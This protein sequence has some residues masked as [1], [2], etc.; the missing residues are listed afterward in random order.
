[1]EGRD[2]Q[3]LPPLV[4]VEDEEVE[5]PWL[6]AHP[7]V[8]EGAAQPAAEEQ[9]ATQPAVDQPPAEEAAA[10]PAIEHQP[11]EQPADEEAATDQPSAEEHGF[12]EPPVVAAEEVSVRSK[13]R[14]ALM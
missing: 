5:E 12:E 3:D 13:R 14:S 11:T 10:Q 1:M 9:A 2:S 8:V 4:I 6:R 7:P